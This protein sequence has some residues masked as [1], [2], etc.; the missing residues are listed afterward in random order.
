MSSS[1]KCKFQIEWLR[2]DEFSGWIYSVER[3]IYSAGCKLCQKEFLLSNMGLRAVKSHAESKRHSD[4]VAS[5]KQQPKVSSLLQSTCSLVPTIHAL[6]NTAPSL[7]SDVSLHTEKNKAIVMNNY[8]IKDDVTKA[9]IRWAINC[10][11]KHQSYRS[12]DGVAD[13]F[14][15][16]FPDSSIA[17]QFSMGRDKITYYVVFGLSPFFLQ[18]VFNQLKLCDSFVVSFDESLNGVLQKEQMD[19]IVRFWDDTAQQ[20]QTKYIGSAFVGRCRAEDLLLHLK[21]TL[22]GLDL[23]KIVQLSMDGPNV[24]WKLFRLLQEKIAEESVD[25]SFPRIL[26]TGCCSLHVVH[27]ALRTGHSKTPWRLNEILRNLYK[28]FKNSPARRSC[29]IEVTNSSQ[30]PK[31][32][33]EVRWTENCAVIERALAIWAHVCKFVREVKPKPTADTFQVVQSASLDPTLIPKLEF[34][35]S[36]SAILEPFLRRFQ[37]SLP[38]IPFLF[39]ELHSIV[40]SLFTRFIKKSVLERG[41]SIQKLCSINLEGDS[42]DLLSL[43]EMD[44]GFGNVI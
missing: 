14:R 33:C 28:L 23:K 36:V 38:I 22:N 42:E 27:G 1:S 21:N 19:I 25:P 15:S 11:T 5:L 26:D 35:L 17:N 7:I 16:M 43:K 29:F 2:K 18:E 39:E 30:F 3:D 12:C 9:E 8:V 32:F 44:V 24:N 10:V 6:S 31:K 34:F 40:M 13:L 20:V 37:T 4:R 41:T